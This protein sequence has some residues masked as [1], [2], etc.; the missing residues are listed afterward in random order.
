MIEG[1]GLYTK[2]GSTKA[3]TIRTELACDSAFPF[4]LG[5][6]VALSIVEGRLVVEKVKT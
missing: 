6:T 4:S 2:F 3:I 1:K 5:D